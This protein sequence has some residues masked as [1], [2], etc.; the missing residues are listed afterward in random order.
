MEVREVKAVST[1]DEA[2]EESKV[3]SPGFRAESKVRE[4]RTER[5]GKYIM[6]IIVQ[7]HKSLKSLLFIYFFSLRFFCPPRWILQRVMVRYLNFAQLPLL[8]LL[9]LL[10][11]SL[12]SDDW[13]TAMHDNYHS[14]RSA[15]VVVPPLALKFKNYE[16][17]GNKDGFP[18]YSNGLL[19]V[20]WSNAQ[21]LYTYDIDASKVVWGND[22]VGLYTNIFYP[23][24]Y[25]KYILGTDGHEGG[26]RI[27]EKATGRKTFNVPAYGN[28]KLGGYT[29]DNGCVYSLWWCE[30]SSNMVSNMI[31]CS[32]VFDDGTADMYKWERDNRVGSFQWGSEVSQMYPLIRDGEYS[33][34]NETMAIPCLVGDT[35]YIESAGNLHAIDMRTGSS[36]WSKGTFWQYYTSVAYE[37]GKLYVGGTQGKGGTQWAT[38]GDRYTPFTI[39]MNCLDAA[40][41]NEI[42]KYQYDT[43]PDYKY[44]IGYYSGMTSPIVSNGVVYFGGT[45]GAFYA[46]DANTGSLKWKYKTE[47]W[48]DD[49]IMPAL[50]GNIVYFGTKGKTSSTQDKKDGVFYA[51]K[52]DTTSVSGECVWKY[53]NPDGRGFGT[54]IVADNKVMVTGNKGYVYAFE[55]Q[56][57]A[58]SLIQ[59]PK[60]TMPLIVKSGNNAVIECSATSSASGWTAKLKKLATEVNLSVT[61]VYDPT[62]CKWNLTTT[63]PSDTQECL[64]DL[65]ITCNEA[66]EVSKN[67]FKV[68]KDYKSNYYY[69][70]ISMTEGNLE[71]LLDQSNIVNPEFI[72]VSGNLVPGGS[73]Y[74]FNEFLNTITKSDVPVFVV[75]GDTDCYGNSDSDTHKLYERIIGPR[76][77]SFNYGNQR[78]VGLDTTDVNGKIGNEQMSWLGAELAGSYD[79]KTIF[80]N[81]D[82]GQIGS[83]C[84][85]Y[86]VD[87][88]LSFAAD[89][90]TTSGV[91]PTKYIKTNALMRVSYGTTKYP[92]FRVVKVGNNKV[93]SSSVE[94]QNWDNPNL[95]IA[96][97]YKPKYDG[98][99]TNDGNVSVN[100]GQ[101]AN[102]H[103]TIY[104]NICIK[105]WMPKDTSYIVHNG[106]LFTV[107]DNGDNTNICYVNSL[108]DRAP[109]SPRY[110]VG[111][112]NISIG[113]AS[114][115]NSAI[116][117]YSDKDLTTELPV[118]V[119]DGSLL[120]R[121]YAK[122]GR[123]YFSVF[124]T[125]GANLPSYKL[126]QQGDL[127]ISSGVLE[128]MDSTGLFYRGY[129]DVTRDNGKEYKDGDASVYVLTDGKISVPAI[130]NIF[131][132][133]TK[134]PEP[135]FKYCKTGPTAVTVSGEAIVVMTIDYDWHYDK[136]VQVYRK[137]LPL[138]DW[139]LKYTHQGTSNYFTYSDTTAVNGTT[140]SY[141]LNQKNALGAYGPY[142]DEYEVTAGSTV[143]SGTAVTNIANTSAVI[144]WTT[145]VPA[146]TQV[147]YAVYAGGGYT[148]FT[149]SDV[150]RWSNINITAE[151]SSLVTTHSVTITG[152]NPSTIYGYRVISK[153]AGG[154]VS[155]YGGIKYPTLSFTTTTNSASIV[156]LQGVPASPKVLPGDI[157][158]VNIYGI[159]GTGTRS[160]AFP[161]GTTL[162]YSVTSGGE[163]V[164]PASTVN[165]YS[166]VLTTGSNVGINTVKSIKTTGTPLTCTTDVEGVVPDHYK[167]ATTSLTVKAGELFNLTLTAYSDVA[168]NVVLPITTT[169]INLNLTAVMGNNPEAN[170]SSILSN[171]LGSLIE[172]IGTVTTSYA[173]V[174]TNGIRVKVEDVKGKTGIS[175]VI[176][177]IADSSKPLKAAGSLSKEQ[178]TSGE[179]VTITGKIL[180]IY[181][182]QITTSGTV[183][184]F[185]VTQGTG[186]LS[187]LTAGTDSNGEAKVN[188][189]LSGS[190][191]N[192][193]EITS[194]SLAKGTVY[195]RTNAVSSVT[196]TPLITSV[197]TGG[198]TEVDVLV[199]DGSDVVVAGTTVTISILSGA[200]SLSANIVIT[201]TTG[202][203]KVSYAAETTAGAVCTIKAE[204]GG[205]SGTAI[206][207]T[208]YGDIDHYKVES[209]V[210]TSLIN[211]DFTLTISAMDK[212]ENLV[213]NASNTVDLISTPTGFEGSTALGTLSVISAVLGS[214]TKTI[215]NER[216]SKAESINIKTIDSNGKYGLGGSINFTSNIPVSI[217]TAVFKYGSMTAT[218]ICT[219]KQVKVFAYIKDAAGNPVGGTTVT[220]NSGGKGTLGSTVTVSDSSG[221]IQNTYTVAD[222]VCTITLTS[223]SITSSTAITGVTPAEI[224]VAEGDTIVAPSSGY[225]VVNIII[226]D[227]TGKLVPFATLTHAI[228]TGTTLTSIEPASP[229]IMDSEG[230]TQLGFRFSAAGTNIVKLTCGSVVRNITA[231]EVS[232]NISMYPA[233]GIYNYAVNSTVSLIAILY[234]SLSQPVP[235]EVVNFSILS[236]GGNLS[237]S[238][239]TTNA[240]GAVF[241]TLTLGSNQEENKIIAEYNGLKHQAGIICSVKPGNIAVSLDSQTIASG[242]TTK[243]NADVLDINGNRASGMIVNFSV[244]SGLGSLSSPTAKTDSNGKASVV[245]TAGAATGNTVIQASAGGISGTA[246]IQTVDVFDLQVSANPS[247]VFI[248]SGASDI[249]SVVKDSNGYPL[250]GSDVL[251]SVVS[252]TGKFVNSYYD[253]GWVLRTVTVTSLTIKANST[254]TSIASMFTNITAAG[255]NIINVS[256]NTLTK[257]ITVK[258]IDTLSG[259]KLKIT[260]PACLATSTHASAEI[261]VQILNNLGETVAAKGVTIICNSTGGSFKYQVG[262]GY[263][264]T[265]AATSPLTLTT[266]SNGKAYLFNNASGLN[267]T[268]FDA[269]A[270]NNTITVSSAGMTSYSVGILGTSV[271]PYTLTSRAEPISIKPLSTCRIIAKMEAGGVSAEGK[272]VSFSMGSS[273]GSL[274]EKNA[275]SSTFDTTTDSN[276]EASCLLAAVDNPDYDYIV[277][278]QNGSNG[279]LINFVTVSTTKTT[280]DSFSVESLNNLLINQPFSMKVKACDVNGGPVNLTSPVTVTISAVLAS[281]GVTPGTGTLNVSTTIIS[282]NID[283]SI[284][285]P[286][287]TYSAAENIKIKITGGGKSSL[288]DA[289]LFTKPAN[290]ISMVLFPTTC[291]A[292]QAVLVDGTI[293][294]VDSKGVSGKSLT[295]VSS[296]GTL[297]RTICI[298][299][300]DGKFSFMLT[301]PA[302]IGTT[303]VTAASG[304]IVGTT[305]VTTTGTIA[306]Y[307]VTAP[308][309]ADINGFNVTITAKD[310]NSNL[311]KS[312]PIV[313]LTTN[314]TGTL[315]LTSVRLTDG[316]LVFSQTYSK[317][318]GPVKITAKDG[319]NKSGI[320]GNI[321]MANSMP[322]VLTITPSSASNLQANTITITGLNFY[323]GT[324]SSSVTAIKLGTATNLSG[325]TCISDSVINSAVVPLKT[326]AGTYDV[327]VYTPQGSNSTSTGKLTLTTT[328]PVITT[329]TP[330]SSAYSQSVTVSISGSGFFA[331]TNSS[332]V[333]SIKVGGTTITT[334]YTV[335]SDTNITGV[336]IPNTLNTGTYNVVVTT[337]GG[338]SSGTQFTVSA[339]PPRVTDVSPNSGYKHLLN[340]INIY[341]NGFF[342]GAGSNSVIGVTMTGPSTVTINP[343][344]V[345][346]DTE[347]QQGVVPTGITA[348]TY[349]V[350]VTTSAGSNTTSTVKYAALTDSIS[351]TVVTATANGS[352]VLITFSEDL[353]LATATNKG[354]YVITSPIGAAKILTSATISYANKVTTIGA[355]TLTSTDSFSVTVTG[356]QDLAGNTI[357]GS[358]IATGTV[359]AA[360]Y[361]PPTA[362]TITI[363]NNAEY[364]NNQNVILNL[365]ATDAISGMS[366]MQFSNDGSTWSTA[367]AYATIKNWNLA[368]VD[369]TKTVYVKYKDNAG[370][371]TGDIADTI[372]MDATAPAGTVSINSGASLTMTIGVTLSIS[373]EDGVGSGVTN[374]QFSN[375]GSTWSTAVAYA[376]GTKTWD[377]ESADGLKTAYVRYT[378]GA[379][380]T[381]DITSTIKLC[382]VN[383]LVV[384][385]P[386]EAI[387]GSSFN[388]TIKAYKD[389]TP[390][391]GY[392]NTVGFSLTDANVVKPVDYVFVS[393]DNG[394]TQVV[395][396]LKTIG[397]QTIEVADKEIAGVKGN[398]EVK[399]YEAVNVD[400]S[401]GTIISNIDGTRIE[402]PA[403][404][405]TG[406]KVVGARVT[407]NPA[408]AA[409]GLRYKATVNPIIRDFGEI[410]TSGTPWTVK[411]MTFSSPVKI[412]IPY[413]PEDIGAMDEN[414]LRIYYYDETTGRYTIVPGTQVVSGGKVT[415]Q[416][417]HFSTYRVFGTYVSSN[418]NNVI[419]YPNPYRPGT[420]VDGKLKI[421]NLPVDCTVT[422]YNIA[423]EKIREIKESDLGNLGWI[424][425]DGKNESNELVARGVYLYVVI[426]PDGSKKIGKI[427]LLK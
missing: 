303:T 148:A 91:T 393:G 367:E 230:K 144:K 42:W 137:E 350:I 1:G 184:T 108:V 37:N 318:E 248:N 130:G 21:D 280:I 45:D 11:S 356:V 348:G 265:Y 416:V 399:V 9:F 166:T 111:K 234:N 294:D 194:G 18:V 31:F 85:A 211:T 193:V 301:T 361:D 331:G 175:D 274:P 358:N 387:A 333:S 5:K 216:Y 55:S 24:V 346:S 13:P 29:Y 229:V 418:L 172:G 159:D 323:A 58:V 221:K 269:V 197:K 370:N 404:A 74:N 365:E 151:D 63:I 207:N 420:A 355:L 153:I 115:P 282:N 305:S 70:H 209:S 281:D 8:F 30:D 195:V 278:I 17:T 186:T 240:T 351:P 203:A 173:I 116:M 396:A 298:S 235:G 379:G 383:K 26:F 124:T 426:A 16:A 337:G 39:Y 35:M 127:D 279:T 368:S 415:A 345:V 288:S 187:S 168:E 300:V 109:S 262:Y 357:S 255:D 372:I 227:G 329:I 179:T 401:M 60:I 287:V 51:C 113:A 414:C 161:F 96:V 10:P 104:D 245:F 40:T 296:G 293:K 92:F 369:G 88:A 53:V 317:V 220:C 181:G 253:S 284:T 226:K 413:L 360:D 381:A 362:T 316:V 202:I 25:D 215:T 412:S 15:D 210:T 341:G 145:T 289:I 122:E 378:D 152:L 28:G 54:V 48:F 324:S 264:P 213:A 233:N 126:D 146:T 64:Y 385:A 347:I 86:G 133:K 286:A 271:N 167:V 62:K 164:N 84:D 277:K 65:Y 325:F 299:D 176:T 339:T 218:T 422:I 410:D 327:I 394:I 107:I 417:N 119:V 366:Q 7:L 198:G 165:A 402:I 246:T 188:L 398:V 36:K 121:I 388:V 81:K 407:E 73:E 297:D 322:V 232:N 171:P 178:A 304:S 217:S 403:G 140:Y 157:S 386:L 139:Q 22:E 129:Y 395:T 23:V 214:G 251:F 136:G 189:T 419:V 97:S 250:G 78:F 114:I 349:N 6:K 391:T 359:T 199:K 98:L 411:N 340:T 338:D 105:F 343:Y 328:A 244:L 380:N 49:T 392:L 87:T 384:G 131:S 183:I 256:C 309:V 292:A 242:G 59:R 425:W 67:S 103:Y 224:Y 390:I 335:A 141:R 57:A 243:V 427:G 196:V 285:L 120:S 68:V 206:I 225:A 160:S 397:K 382:T 373:A 308:A 158:T 223:G 313:A 44:L 149:Y 231:K 314:G 75:P 2:K 423:G 170:A 276:G 95:K 315:G 110:S 14:G 259:L 204:T 135:Y 208:V 90:S 79:M 310:S 205:I 99:S 375:D 156:S 354:N 43:V 47:E 56:P 241:T 332:D 257:A 33:C 376:A 163:S 408:S 326:K 134:I 191:P 272:S 93:T 261:Y 321:T 342:A 302:S 237:V 72:I 117:Y 212:Y 344:I 125:D 409:T 270:G 377:L 77:Y 254:G 19:H 147:E 405:F 352:Q 180:D 201:D 260:A 406:S 330:N 80:Y 46:L 236:G 290:S 312:S 364:T 291:V 283:S 307:T 238:S 334:A 306:S 150:S 155:T 27:Y 174:E 258:S 106:E 374:M 138:G 263:P 266:T 50:S 421:I 319:N 320:T 69:M 295:I 268:G 249:K 71:K 83:I 34:M 371:W 118:Y 311:V 112:K 273:Y 239:G 267:N 177:V 143:I 12:R 400:G 41:G 275:W 38:G 102:G 132:A 52:T 252:G 169:N 192:T 247:V 363:N 228:T 162:N 20:L 94:P 61:P 200:G 389:S 185:N 101:V 89:A 3:W 142:T 66:S 100:I 353:S 424:E 123:T 222:G 336:V 128:K 219:G 190:N 76:Y 4:E 32:K 82:T 182:N 154:G